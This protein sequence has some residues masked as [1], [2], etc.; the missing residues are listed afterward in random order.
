MKKLNFDIVDYVD[1]G[2]TASMILEQV[3][4]IDVNAKLKVSNN[5]PKYYFDYYE[6][7]QIG[8]VDFSFGENKKVLFFNSSKSKNEKFDDEHIVLSMGN[9]TDSN[10]LMDIIISNLNNIR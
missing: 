8:R 3:K 4:K 1:K 2:I 9:T 5:I 10:L 7:C 6:N